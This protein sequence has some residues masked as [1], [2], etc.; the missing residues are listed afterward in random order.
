MKILVL[1]NDFPNINN[2][3]TTNIFVKEQVKEISKFLDE[4]NVIVPVP[5]GIEVKR[6][7][8]YKNYKIGDKVSVHFIRYLNPLFPISYYIL[9]NLWMWFESVALRKYIIKNKIEFDLIHAHYTWPNGVLGLNLKKKYGV[10]LVVTEH[11][12]QTFVKYFKKNDEY[13]FKTWKEVD[14]IIRMRKMDIYKFSQAEVNI[15]RLFY[16]PNGFD[17]EKFHPENSQLARREL[18]LPFSKKIIINVAQMYSP[19]KGHKYLVEA[20]KIVLEQRVDVL[21]IMIGDGVLRGKIENQAKSLGE[22]IKFVGSKPHN[23]IP[24][25]MNAAD[26]F[27]LP[28]LRESFGIVQIEAMA[29]GVPIVAT[30]NGGSEEIITSEDYGLLCEPGNPEDLAEKILTALEKEWNREKIRNYAEQFTWENIAKKTLK[31]Y[32]ECLGN[33]Q[34]K[35]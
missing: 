34:T 24:L 23:E 33:N 9:R 29:C 2:S 16:I 22:Y 8:R 12:S 14:A 10:P 30:R 32:E 3:Y 7:T 13:I 28:S 1:V 35:G 26:L 21:C 15:D 5:I 31:V 6:K 25:W 20:M 11:T 19:V 17:Q 18:K 27:V 4:V